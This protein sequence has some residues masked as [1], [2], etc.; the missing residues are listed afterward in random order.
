MNIYAI[1]RP[2]VKYAV[3][4]A[5]I[6]AQVLM[7]AQGSLPSHEKPGMVTAEKACAS[8]SGKTIGGA[9]LTTLVVKA[10]GAVPTYC[11]VNG[12]IAP[13]LNFE[14]RLPNAWNGKLYYGGGGGYDGMLCH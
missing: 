13:S 8:L 6:S 12:A 4:L 11:K 1:P 10:T 3:A 7:W 2:Q 14:I 5:A 9:T